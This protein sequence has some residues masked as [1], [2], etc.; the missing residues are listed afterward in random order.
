[1]R[2]VSDKS[3]RE[4]QNTLFVFSIFFFEYRSVY[5][6]M[7]KNTVE[8]GRPQMTIWRMRFICWITNATNTHSQ[9]AILIAFPLQQRLRERASKLLHM[10]NAF[11]FPLRQ[12]LIKTSHIKQQEENRCVAINGRELKRK[13]KNNGMHHCYP[14]TS[15]KTRQHT[16]LIGTVRNYLNLLRFVAIVF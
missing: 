12:W 4:N 6:N 14:K 2:N 7:W 15:T 13:K 16:D 8:P 9:Y 1:M 3:C 10:Y 5:E 11:L